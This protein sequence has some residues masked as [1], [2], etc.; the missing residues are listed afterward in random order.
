MFGVPAFQS[1]NSI[2]LVALTL[3][4][5]GKSGCSTAAN[6]NKVYHVNM[7]AQSLLLKHFLLPNF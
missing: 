6:A 5:F 1:A 7:H 2:K 3:A 4:G